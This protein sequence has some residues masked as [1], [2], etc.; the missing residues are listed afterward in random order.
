MRIL[1][2]IY[3]SYAAEHDIN[4]NPDK[5]KFL[6]IPAI[7]RRHLYNAMCNCSFFV[8]NKKL[9]DFQI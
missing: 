8:G 1:L 2:Q 5:S 9:L 4:L 6:V 3:D 7:K